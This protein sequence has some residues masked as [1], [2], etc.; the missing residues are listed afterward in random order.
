MSWGRAFAYLI[1][2][3]NSAAFIISIFIPTVFGPFLPSQK[4]DVTLAYGTSVWILPVTVVV[5]A[6]T[7][8]GQTR[9]LSPFAASISAALSILIPCIIF[10]ISF[11]L[12]PLYGGVLGNSLAYTFMISCI[13]FM[14]KW[15][16]KLDYVRDPSIKS[17]AKIAKIEIEHEKY[18][19]ILILFVV[20]ISTL[21]AVTV[22]QA[23]GYYKT[24]YPSA[25]IHEIRL[26]SAINALY[27]AF[28]FVL[29]LVLANEFLGKMLKMSDSLLEIKCKPRGK[30]EKQN[31]DK[32]NQ[33]E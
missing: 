32:K 5:F 18:L 19:R 11:R 6:V 22:F 3:L 16:V 27:S 23:P 29:M 21:S 28:F 13:S 30:Q 15:D 33:T 10:V 9:F 2:V 1:A 7:C 14:H 8:F 4:L 31:L 24:A 17:Q 20:A 25:S 26:F 12:I